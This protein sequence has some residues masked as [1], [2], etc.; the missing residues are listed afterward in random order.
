[1]IARPEIWQETASTGVSGAL[2]RYRWRICALLFCATTINYVDRQVLGVLA[3]QLQ[4]IIGWNEIQY[5]YIVTAFQAAYALGLLGVGRFI[6]RFGTRVGY[7]VAIGVWSLAAMGHALVHTALGFGIARFV[8]GLGESG[9]FPAALKAVSEWFPRKERTLATGIFN[10][11]SNVGAIVA[12]LM[13]PWIA[14]KLGWRFAFLFTGI[15]SSAWLIAWLTMYRRPREFGAEPEAPT[16][17][18]PAA[19]LLALPQTWVFIAGKFITDPVWWFLL[20]WLPKFLNSQHGLSLIALG[21]PLVAIYLMADAGSIVGGWLASTFMKHGWS[22]NRARKTAMLICAITV[23]PIVFAANV[24][25]VWAAVALLGLGAASH[26]GW[27]AN[28]FTLVPDLFPRHA[29]ASV[30]GM[31]GFGGAIGGMLIST[32]TG[33]LLQ[34]T[35]SYVPVFVLAGSTYLIALGLIHILSP[36]LTPAALV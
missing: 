18:I 28:L 4:S 35:G 33:F 8:L 21:P 34:L 24:R 26:Q 29:V 15:F 6:D 20:F 10:A 17:K 27:S 2:G 5:G 16:A 7:A 25:S 32:F 22:L 1:M 12:P 14:V 9:N 11:G 19:Q 36:K 31:G 13:V 30:V 23:T 3:P